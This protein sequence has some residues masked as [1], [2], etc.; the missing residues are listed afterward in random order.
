M[1]KINIT[2]PEGILYLEQFQGLESML[3]Q[4]S[5]FLDKKYTGCGATTMFLA[6]SVPTILCSAR[7]ELMYSKANSKRFKGKVYLFRQEGDKANP[8]ELMNKMMMYVGMCD[9]PWTT[10]TPKIIVTYDSFKHV[11]QALTENGCKDRFRVIVDEAQ[12]LFTDASFKGDV[13]IEFL[14]NLEHCN[15]VIFLSATQYMEKYLSAIPCFAG[16]P[17]VELQWPNSAIHPTNIE[18]KA[19]HIS[20]RTTARDIINRFREDQYFAAKIVNGQTIYSEEIVF[21][22]NDVSLIINIVQDNGLTPDETNII[23]ADTDY[24][25]RRLNKI[26][27]KIGHAPQEGEPHKT[28]TFA[29]KCA[30][31]GVDFNSTCAYTVIFSDCKRENLS[32]DIS[33]DLPQ[34]MGR[35]RLGCNVFRYDATFYYR[36]D[37]D[38]SEDA[39]NEFMANVAEKSS[40]TDEIIHGFNQMS[41]RMKKNY[42]AKNRKSES[43]SLD[44]ATV[45]DDRGSGSLQLVFNHLAM[46]NEIRAWDV[47]K[48]QYANGC[49]IMRAIDDS[50]RPVTDEPAISWFL[51]QMT[52][53]FD[54]NLRLYCEFLQHKPQYKEWLEFL[55]QI[56]IKIKE[57][58]NSYGPDTLRSWGY[59]ES[60][61]NKRSLDNNPFAYED[62]KK[63]VEKSFVPG[64]FYTLKQTKQMLQQ[65]YDS[66]NVADTAKANDLE[67]FSYCEAGKQT[68]GGK[69]ENGYTFRGIR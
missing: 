47:Q 48:D 23:C 31:E 56:P 37:F 58:Y 57:Y 53:D 5:F 66:L 40:L 17:Y 45:I 26:G 46:Q 52:K 62:A 27:F 21:F 14:E 6:D 63:R 9:A 4:G 33:L 35:Q 43:D 12:T 30:F 7:K 20:P 67:R 1:K 22:L 11:L 59:K 38:F 69:R 3:P 68:R 15:N 64:T 50:T 28:F 8:L 42:A 51:T 25:L 61:I 41:G 2:V 55:P 54:A 32:L 18:R 44:Y 65:I 16:L 10:M 24:N 19:Y 39:Y 13:E 36:S 60:N 34:C 29:T 49:Q